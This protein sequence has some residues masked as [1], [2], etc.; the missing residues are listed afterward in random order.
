MVSSLHTQAAIILGSVV[1]SGGSF[2]VVPVG[3]GAFHGRICSGCV[4]G[5]G[6]AEGGEEADAVGR[7]VVWRLSRADAIDRLCCGGSV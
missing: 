5:I 4:Q 7:P 2:R 3:S 1:L 6:F